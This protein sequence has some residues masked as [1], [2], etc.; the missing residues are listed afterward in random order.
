MTRPL[1]RVRIDVGGET[2]KRGITL[3]DHV[4]LAELIALHAVGILRILCVPVHVRTDSFK[5]WARLS[6]IA[7][8]ILRMR[9]P[10]RGVIFIDERLKNA[11]DVRL[12]RRAIGGAIILSK[13]RCGKEQSAKSQEHNQQS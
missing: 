2:N 12:D 4:E 10:Q 13:N 11:L 9:R 3:E 8:P 1:R 7:E 5:H 6:E